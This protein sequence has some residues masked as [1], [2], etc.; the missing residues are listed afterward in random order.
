MKKVLIIVDYQ[1]DFV[2]GALGFKGADRLDVIIE[3][4]IK[5]YLKNGND[6]IYTLD[7]H[8]ENYLE[9]DEGRRLPILHCIE[10]TKGHLI[11]GNVSKYVD[12]A[13]KIFKKATFGSLDLGNFLKEEKYDEIEIAGLVTNMCVISNAVIAKAALPNAKIFVDSKA[14][15]SF[16]RKLHDKTLDLLKGLHTDIL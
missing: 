14:V 6:I 10:G 2:D 7:T 12:Q 3:D 11:Y 15:D 8:H 9:T 1:N 16:D 13:K 5:D 4:K